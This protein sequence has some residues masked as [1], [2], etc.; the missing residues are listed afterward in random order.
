MTERF[1]RFRVGA[2]NARAAGEA[3]TRGSD[4]ARSKPDYHDTFSVQIEQL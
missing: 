4:A 3:Q 1:V 2:D